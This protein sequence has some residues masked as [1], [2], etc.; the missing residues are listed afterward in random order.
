MHQ[1]KNI[2]QVY[3]DFEIAALHELVTISGSLIIGLALKNKALTFQEAWNRAI[4]DESW[5]MQKWGKDQ[6]SLD[7]LKLRRKEF[8]TAYEFLKLLE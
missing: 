7:R 8:S 4:L 1:L 3:S 5:Q 2:L 6:E